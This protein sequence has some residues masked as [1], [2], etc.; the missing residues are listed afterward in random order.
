MFLSEPQ[1][2]PCNDCGA[3]VARTERDVHTCEV[4]RRLDYELFQLRRVVADFDEQF[5]VYLESPMGRFEVWYAARTRRPLQ[6][7]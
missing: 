4:E 5:G 2:M 1:H 7:S 3:S 6:E